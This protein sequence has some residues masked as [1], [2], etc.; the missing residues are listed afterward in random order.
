MKKNV[1]HFGLDSGFKA[2]A[3]DHNVT[4]RTFKG[5]YVTVKPSFAR[6]I[7]DAI[8]NIFGL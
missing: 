7:V 6:V 5:E 3:R 1:L 8:K 4:R 2:I